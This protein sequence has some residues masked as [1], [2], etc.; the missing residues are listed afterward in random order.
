MRRAGQVALLRFPTTELTPGKPR[1][2]LL[3]APTPGPYEDWL[4][5]MISTRIRQALESFDEVIDQGTEDFQRSGL[6][7]ASVV[8]VSRLAVVAT[9]TL[10]GTVGQI[11]PERL[12]RIRRKLVGWIEGTERVGA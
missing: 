3:I 12:E 9:E 1:P 6:K 2:V 4:V 11:S 8:R 10:V 7:V 5:C